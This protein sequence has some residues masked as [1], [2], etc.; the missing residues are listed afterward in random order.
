[1]TDTPA[2]IIDLISRCTAK[3]PGERPQDFVD[4]CDVIEKALSDRSAPT[5]LL[6]AQ[7][8]E[9]RQRAPAGQAG[10]AEDRDVR[11]ARAV[12][13]GDRGGVAAALG[14]DRC[15]SDPAGCAGPAQ[16]A[17]DLYRKNGPG[18][19]GKLPVRAGQTQVST[20]AYYIDE[21]EVSNAVYQ[22]FCRATG[23]R[24]LPKGFR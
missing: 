8:E 15:G 2:A 6:P 23:I 11:S 12:G 3:N 19:A 10:L 1:M 14:E 21:T 18:A 7:A 17:G 16:G 13:G 9:R 20:P 4:V 22:Q 24:A 5:S